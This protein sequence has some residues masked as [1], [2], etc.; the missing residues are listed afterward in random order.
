MKIQKIMMTS[1]AVLLLVGCESE[2]IAS[3]AAHTEVP[4][5]T[6]TI[7]YDAQLDFNET[8]VIYNIEG[9]SYA[10]PE[11][12]KERIDENG[13]RNYYPGNGDTDRGFIV[14]FLPVEYT[15]EN[16]PE[17]IDQYI[18][19]M[20]ADAEE[21]YSEKVTAN[22]N[23]A[24]YLKCTLPKQGD[25]LQ[26]YNQVYPVNEIGLFTIAYASF[27]GDEDEE[28]LKEIFNSVVLPEKQQ[29]NFGVAETPEET[30]E[31]Q[32]QEEIVENTE[33]EPTE[34]TI[35]YLQISVG[36][37]SAELDNNAL[38]AKETYK[39]QML[40]ITGKLD[41][42]DASGKYISLIGVDEYFSLKG[43]QCYAKNDYQKSQIMEMKTGDIIT[44]RGK[45]TSVGEL[46]GYSL[47]ITEIF[48]YEPSGD[49]SQVTVDGYIV[50]T[51]SDL[52]NDLSNNAM[53]AKNMY[54]DHQVAITG[55]VSNIASNGKYI[56]LEPTDNPYSL[57]NIQCFIKSTEVKEQV[58]NLNVGDIVTVKGKCTSVGELL[59]YSI[60]IET[61]E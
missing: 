58:L 4:S 16:L 45:C 61:I 14:S 22:G 2:S 29:F 7:G 55:K 18:S 53:K 31:P 44:L 13:N 46:L 59:G 38:K 48:G 6:D 43:V 41:N 15:E 5:Q 39:N 54:E 32:V 33:P 10:I 40:E 26:I 47:D 8:K 21:S 52:V 36:Q 9:I 24:W 60:N 28:I 11:T 42:I 49:Q 51:A 35:Q 1:A 27:Q 12:W 20:T 57:T 37:L 34:E 3:P 30:A 56:N 50:R 23:D 25:S 17:L 19:T